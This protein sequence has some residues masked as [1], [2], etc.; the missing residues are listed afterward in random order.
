MAAL[1]GR[2]MNSFWDFLWLLFWSYI[3]VSVIIILIQ[4]FVDLFRDRM[5][6]GWAKALWVIFLVF[7]PFLGA[8]IYLITRGRGMAQ[9]H[10]ARAIQAQSDSEDFIRAAAGTGGGSPTEEIG[11][12]KALLDSGAITQAE[13]NT[14]KSR[15][16]A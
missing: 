11:R 2:T 16:L 13:Y 9:R 12:A 8:L 10:G 5:L 15:M 3:F 1:K 14:L 6:N 7:L 4:I